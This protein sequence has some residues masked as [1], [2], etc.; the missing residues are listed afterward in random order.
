[1][2]RAPLRARA[3]P[4]QDGFSFAPRSREIARGEASPRRLD[5]L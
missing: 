2:R 3:R 1:M 5:T 4:C